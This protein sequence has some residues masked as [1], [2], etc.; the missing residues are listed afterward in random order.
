MATVTGKQ[1]LRLYQDGRAAQ[2]ALYAIRNVTTGDT[3]D[4][5]PS[6]TGDFL[7]VKQAAMVGSTVAGSAA[8]TVGGG[9]V[10]TMPAGL[11]GDSLY[12]LAWGDAAL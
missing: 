7:A 5:G 3:C 6:G 1:V 10:V 9:T 8:V 11:S 12:L 4:L 2:L